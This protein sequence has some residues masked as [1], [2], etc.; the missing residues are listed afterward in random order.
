MNG[1]EKLR[2]AKT[3]K[4]VAEA[5]LTI[6]KEYNL[7]NN[8]LCLIIGFNHRSKIQYKL[9]KGNFLYCEINKLLNYIG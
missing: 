3:N 2:K 8:K 5:V 9:D 6:K 7:T 4:E 1:K